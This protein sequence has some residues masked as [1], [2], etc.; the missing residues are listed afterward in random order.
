MDRRLFRREVDLERL[1]F[2]GRERADV[3]A[4]SPVDEP[5][6]RVERLSETKGLDPLP[7]IDRILIEKVADLLRPWVGTQDATPPLRLQRTRQCIKR[8]A[9]PPF[10]GHSNQAL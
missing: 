5:R 2:P 6:K 1:R 9:L 10:A 8:G 4:P 7:V 3:A